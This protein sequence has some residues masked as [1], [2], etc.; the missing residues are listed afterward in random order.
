[1]NSNGKSLLEGRLQF[2]GVRIMTENLTLHDPECIETVLAHLKTLVSTNYFCIDFLYKFLIRV[3]LIP[4]L[5]TLTSCI[6]G[7]KRFSFRC[8]HSLSIEHF[9]FNFNLFLGSSVHLVP[10]VVEPSSNY[11]FVD[12]FC[13]E[14]S[15]ARTERCGHSRFLRHQCLLQNDQRLF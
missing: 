2:F 12:S 10:S 13:G 4:M 14:T 6:L 15:L 5:S 11:F 9:S 8:V 7:K 3:I 1:M